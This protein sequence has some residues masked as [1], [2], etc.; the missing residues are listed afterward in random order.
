MSKTQS[1][2]SREP[3]PETNFTIRINKKLAWSILAVL[4]GL[5]TLLVF[6]LRA[7]QRQVEASRE[8]ASS[9]PDIA[10][11]AG[12][13]VADE[14]DRQAKADLIPESGPLPQTSPPT[15]NDSQSDWGAE[16]APV[17]L[18]DDDQG[19]SPVASDGSVLPVARDVAVA[20]Q[21]ETAVDQQ[22]RPD[23]ATDD[24][25]PPSSPETRQ[26][27]PEPTPSSPDRRQP[28]AEP[29]A[30]AR[31]ANLNGA[32]ATFPNPIYQK[33]FTDFHRDHPNVQINYQS[34]GS[35]G[36]IAQLQA[37]TVDFAATDGPMTDEQ[38]AQT[39]IKVMHIPTVLGA[40]VPIY[41]LP[42]V[43]AEIKFTAEALAGIFLGKIRVWD[44]PALTAVNPGILLPNRVIEV[45]HRSDPAAANYVFTDF[46]SK[47]SSD[48]RNTV[49][50]GTQVNWPLGTGAKGNEGVFGVVRQTVGAIGYVELVYALQNRM[51]YGSVKNPAGRFVKASLQS[52][53]AAA[54]S[55]RD[56]PQDF[57]VS[58]TNAPG[59]DAYPISSFTWL[60]VP[61]HWSDPAKNQDMRAFLAWMIDKGQASASELGYAPLP[62]G[63]ATSLKRT[64]GQMR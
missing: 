6:D 35:G 36:G 45:I 55:V 15:P 13:K 58:I 42:G 37:G 16:P 50:A 27:D 17:R 51:Q 41:N 39:K 12:Q 60:L 22:D 3:H 59:T 64:I 31:I 1:P 47:A 20:E 30:D 26:P 38:L 56:M 62:Q 57:R 8:T 7:R 34:I 4:V 9:S 10:Y 11:A 49:F 48:W 43:N 61:Q 52:V 40:V 18:H 53:T 14:S 44:D 46:L 32:G 23:N 21:S 5:A 24:A 29:S 2:F 33:W 25:P 54:A 28:R 63:V 19:P